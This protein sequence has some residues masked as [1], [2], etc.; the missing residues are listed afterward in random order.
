MKLY[1][2]LIFVPLAIGARVLNLSATIVFVLSFLAMIPLASLISEAVDVLAIYAGP[3]LGAL[4]SATFGTLTEI[5]I[6]FN[7]LWQGQ[8]AVMQSEITGSVL[9]G[10]LFTIGLSQFAGGI[11]YGFQ[12]FDVRSVALATAL[13][14]IAVIG[15][16]IPTFFAISQQFEAGTS[17]AAGYQSPELDTLS[18]GVSIVLMVLYVLYLFFIFRYVPARARHT[19]RE[20]GPTETPEW[21]KQRGLIVLAL[22]TA[23]VAIMSS[24]LTGALEPF[25]ESIGLSTLFLG[26]I[27]LPIAGS[28]ADITVAARAA[29]NNKI[30]L[31][32]SLG[33]S[34]VLQTALLVAPLMVLISPLFQQD[35]TLSFGLIQVL[36]MGIAVA[37]LSLTVNDGVSNWFE[38]AQFLGLYGILALWFFLTT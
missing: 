27:V 28:F 36:A 37:V 9:L 5:F 23:G 15:M 2:L 34:A 33:T 13:T 8:I 18:H 32:F 16:L 14:A 26:L 30:G 1:W 4:L 6:L 29:R 3:S 31:S 35:F 10:L 22:A 21:S 20:A 11:K 17:I 25:G 19:G 7:L 12:E 38:G 24:I